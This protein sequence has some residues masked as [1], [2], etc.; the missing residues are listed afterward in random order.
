MGKIRGSVVH[1]NFPKACFFPNH[2][3][4]GR[5]RMHSRITAR[6]STSSDPAP[7]QSAS[8]QIRGPGTS[9]RSRGHAG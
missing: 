8:P 4:G 3:P 2:V 6:M 5:L 7:A 9:V 1:R